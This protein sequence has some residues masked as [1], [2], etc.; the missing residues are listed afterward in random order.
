MYALVGGKI[1]FREGRTDINAV[2]TSWTAFPDTH[3]VF[4]H[5]DAGNRELWA[6]NVYNEIYRRHG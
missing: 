6:V 5:I 3:Q 4:K 1:F 2:G